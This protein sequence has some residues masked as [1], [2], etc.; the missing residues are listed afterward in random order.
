MT[1]WN[2]LRSALTLVGLAAVAVVGLASAAE[3]AIRVLGAWARATPPGAENGAVY[4]KIA[5][6]GAADRLIGA[7]TPAARN[8]DLHASATSDGVVTMRHLDALPIAPSATVELAPGGTH[9]MLVG[10]GSQ[11]EPGTHFDLTLIFAIAG[12]IAV[13]VTV[14]DPRGPPAA[15]HEHEHHTP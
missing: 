14:V 10:L 2:R 5:N 1:T 12:E 13:D 9:V 3:P 11:L 4:L 15:A 6:H 7:R 8:A